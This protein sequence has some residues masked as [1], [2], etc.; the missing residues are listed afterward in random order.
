MKRKLMIYFENDQDKLPVTY[1]LRMLTRRAM[2]ATL[3]YEAVDAPY[4]EVSL[5]F[6]DNEGIHTLNRQYRG[7]DKP[8]D[9]LSFPNVDYEVPSD[10]SEI[11]KHEADYLD[12]ETGELVLGDIILSADKVFEQAENY[13]HSVKREFA[14]LISHS[15]LHLC[16]YDHMEEE[17]RMLMEEKQRM[18]LSRVQ[19][20]RED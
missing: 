12:P 10:F 15:M 3:D 17:E 5:T 14:F 1:K 2:I 20:T 19:I 4:C 16:G 18:I 11:A 9:V 8:T 7:V 6:T 13:G